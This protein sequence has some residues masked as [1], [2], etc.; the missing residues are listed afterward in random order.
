MIFHRVK[1]RLSKENWVAIAIDLAIVVIGVFLGIQ[2]SNWNQARLERRQTDELLL[3]M[4]PELSRMRQADA[5]RLDYYN[6]T[7][8][9]A[10]T[11]LAAWANDPSITDAQFV[12]AA[13][14]ASQ[15]TGLNGD[16]PLRSLLGPTDVRNI[17]DP[18]LRWAL[19]RLMNFDYEAVSTS[20]M[21]TRY[22]ENVREILP[23]ESQ[24]AIRRY[25]G[26]KTVADGIPVLPR[27]CEVKI[28]ASAVAKAAAELR[29]HPELTSQLRFHM[30]QAANF[31]TNTLWLDRIV[32]KVQHLLNDK[33]GSES[34]ATR[35]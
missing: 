6:L 1:S 17:N 12:I 35:Q 30:A 8:A 2:A 24:E 22:R 18:A 4:R 26:D 16:S 32:S 11:A 21:Q 10:R 23:E 29:R 27:T 5:K 15:I 7:E 13:Y 28:E 19:L 9:Y 34:P 25:C 31:E 3:E 14:Q 33:F 20:A